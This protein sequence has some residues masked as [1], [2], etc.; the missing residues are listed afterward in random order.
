MRASSAPAEAM[1]APTR[2]TG[3][4]PLHDPASVAAASG[5]AASA[6]ASGPIARGALDVLE[7]PVVGKETHVANPTRFSLT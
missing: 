1:A 6:S 3:V 5:A 4:S 2:T 7:H